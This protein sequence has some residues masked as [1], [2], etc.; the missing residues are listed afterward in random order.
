MNDIIDI[1]PKRAKLISAILEVGLFAIVILVIANIQFNNGKIAQCEEL[2]GKVVEHTRKGQYCELN[3]N[4][5]MVNKIENGPVLQP[6]NF[7]G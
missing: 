2:G 5:N 6:Y 1:S 4:E 7:S 3:F